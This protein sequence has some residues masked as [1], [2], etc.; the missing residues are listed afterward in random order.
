MRSIAKRTASQ[1]GASSGF[2]DVE[3]E[4]GGFPTGHRDHQAQF[5]LL[6]FDL[7]RAAEQ[8][9]S[10]TSDRAPPAD[11]TGTSRVACDPHE[12]FDPGGDD[13]GSQCGVGNTD[14]RA[15]PVGPH[16]P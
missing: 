10:R 16:H 11:T 15:G 3:S 8:T 4:G 9:L 6:L 13:T 1:S 14:P 12:P 7:V 5:G 2:V